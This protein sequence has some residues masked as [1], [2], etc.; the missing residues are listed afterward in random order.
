MRHDNECFEFL[1]EH[2]QPKECQVEPGTEFE[3]SM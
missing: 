3:N 1:T 2:E